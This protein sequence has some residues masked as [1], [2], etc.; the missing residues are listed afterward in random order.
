MLTLYTPTLFVSK[1]KF[2]LAEQCNMH[3]YRSGTEV[4]AFYY[5]LSFGFMNNSLSNSLYIISNRPLIK[6][7]CTIALNEEM[8]RE[9]KVLLYCY[10]NRTMNM[11]QEF[12]PKYCQ[13]P[14]L[15]A[16]ICGIAIIW[17]NLLAF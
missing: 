17:Y 15:Q 5:L 13:S 8:K 12:P 3:T 7:C 9:K 1:C 16:R 2:Y 4:V 14:S 10:L 11:L 6:M